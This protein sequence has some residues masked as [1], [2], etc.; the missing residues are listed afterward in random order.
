MRIDEKKVE[1]FSFLAT[2]VVASID[3]SNQIISTQLCNQSRDVSELA[4]CTHEEA[5]TRIILHLDDAVKEGNTK[6][7]IC[8]VDTDLVVLPVTSA[9]RLNNAEVWI[10]FGTGKCFSFI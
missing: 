4:P 9:Q 7:S 10:A 2:T 6:V 3:C 5:D 1:L 8:T